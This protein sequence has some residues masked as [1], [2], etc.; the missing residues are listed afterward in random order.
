MMKLIIGK[1]NNF[2]QKNTATEANSAQNTKN[3]TLMIA[4]VNHH[5]NTNKRS[6]NYEIFIK[7]ARTRG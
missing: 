7:T 2:C 1:Y 3:S 6:L 4:N 5:D